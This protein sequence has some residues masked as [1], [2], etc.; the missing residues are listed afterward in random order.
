MREA[1][2]NF[3][4]VLKDERKDIHIKYKILSISSLSFLIKIDELLGV[5]EK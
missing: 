1:R 4:E 3:D 2:K 5:N